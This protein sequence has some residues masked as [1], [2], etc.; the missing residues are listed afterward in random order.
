MNDAL[1]M[2]RAKRELTVK[3]EPMRRF[4]LPA[5][6]GKGGA[7]R[8]GMQVEGARGDPPTDNLDR[9]RCRGDPRDDVLRVTTCA[10]IDALNSEI[11]GCRRAVGHGE[12]V[13][14]EAS[15]WHAFRRD[16]GALRD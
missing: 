3:G 6:I 7:A 10:E 15:V 13:T 9:P 8:T 11:D 1:R 5:A 4:M 12:L 16:A 2:A 14:H